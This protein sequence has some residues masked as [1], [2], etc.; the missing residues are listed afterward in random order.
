MID[1]EPLIE[2]RLDRWVPPVD[3]GEADWGD[4]LRRSGADAGGRLRRR[5]LAISIA[6]AAVAAI[7]ATPLGGAIVR[8]VGDF[9][10]WLTGVPGKPADPAE[11]EAFER[12]NNRSWSAFPDGPMLRTLIETNVGGHVY[13][14]FGFRSGGSFCL[15]LVARGLN[16]SPVVSCA[17]STELRVAS[18]PALVVLTDHP[19]GLSHVI[20][21]GQEYVPPTSSATFGVVADGVDA[22]EL[23]TDHGTRRAI[24]RSN[25][26]LLISARPKVGQRVRKVLA[27]T[28]GRRRAVPFVSAPFGTWDTPARSSAK[29][30][31]PSQVER[32]IKGGRIAW[33]ERRELRGEAIPD[34]APYARGPTVKGFDFARLLTPDPESHMRILVGIGSLGRYGVKPG[35]DALCSALVAGGGSGGTCSSLAGL[36][37]RGPL[38]WS[39][40]LIG[41]GDQYETISGVASDDVARLEIFFATGER[42]PVPLR[43]NAFLVQ[44]ARA[45]YPVRLVAYDDDGLVVAVDTLPG[46]AAAGAGPRPVGRWRTILTS[47]DERGEE[48]RLRIARSSRGGLCH[49]FRLPGGAGG[50]GCAVKDPRRPKLALGFSPGWLTGTVGSDVAAIE[51]RFADGAR[52][53]VTPTRGF[54]LTPI[55]SERDR[56]LT[57]VVGFDSRGRTI[58]QQRFRRHAPG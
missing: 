36:F 4:V 10:A 7:V 49:E 34:G 9:S 50:G 29:P 30:T 32:T 42:R 1:V 25:A 57:L 56:E 55:P 17:P 26:F 58:A 16:G 15:R 6:V 54:V 40:S 39:Q 51:L 41:G 43:D 37:R 33:I 11:Q 18:A 46:D 45:K 5:L 44:A 19:F 31:G 20:P 13:E 14:L 28:P 23:V 53:R 22:V 21:V 35:E 2:D 27:L 8:G 3:P 47:R 12:A 24:V 48:A 38:M 52:R